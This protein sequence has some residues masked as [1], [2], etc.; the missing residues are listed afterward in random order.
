M[1]PHAT[2][3]PAAAA[4][5]AEVLVN[6]TPG[7]ASMALLTAIGAPALA[8]EVLLDEVAEA[9]DAVRGLLSAPRPHGSSERP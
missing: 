1:P 9:E 5:H 2:E 6:A 3:D 7:T 8:G 4:A